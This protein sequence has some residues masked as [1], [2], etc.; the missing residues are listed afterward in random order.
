MRLDHGMEQARREPQRRHPV[1]GEDGG[2]L[3]EPRHARRVDH[4]PPAVAERAPDLEGRGVER[5]RRQLE[6]GLP[7]PE[8]RIAALGDQADDAAMLDRHALWPAGRARGVHH[9]GEA[10]G[11][12]RARRA[13]RRPRPPPRLRRRRPGTAR[14]WRRRAGSGRAPAGRQGRPAGR[15]RRPSESRAGARGSRANAAREAPPAPPAPR[16]AERGRGPGGWCG[17]RARCRRR[18][19]RPPPGPPR[20]AAPWRQ[21]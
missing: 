18:A 2:Q 10:L 1:G 12:R 5:H 13:G 6:R 17:S 11:R 8:G 14:T 15:R 16:R 3:V 19:P 4:Q 20:P 21:H 9:V 7:R